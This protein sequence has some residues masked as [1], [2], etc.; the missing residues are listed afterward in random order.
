MHD[1][2][3]LPFPL[4]KSDLRTRIIEKGIDMRFLNGPGFRGR[5]GEIAVLENMQKI[6]PAE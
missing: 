4:E 3:F 6:H 2:F 1:E 5:E